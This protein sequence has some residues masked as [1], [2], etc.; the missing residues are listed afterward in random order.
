M[1]EDDDFQALFFA[2][3][4]ELLGDLQEQL[5]Q[6]GAGEDDPEIV[7]AAFRAVHSVKGGAAA[8][9][10]DDLISFAHVF[11]TVM[12]KL[13]NDALTRTPE[14]LTLLARSGDVLM[15]LVEAARDGSEPD[16]PT[17]ERALSELHD[18]AGTKPADEEGDGGEAPA[19][20][21]APAPAAPAEAEG[22]TER[23]VV[24]R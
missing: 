5:D 17:M 9:G 3:C 6:L 10:F 13:R 2:E 18:Y 4:V 14:L 23:E 16:R 22:A 24:V 15:E 7:N 19:E 20:A 21:A 1:D 8:F 12:D 11:E